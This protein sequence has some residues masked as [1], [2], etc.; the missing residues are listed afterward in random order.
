MQRKYAWCLAAAVLVGGC[1]SYYR[2]ADPASGKI[3]YTKS[4]KKE[5]GGAVMLKDAATGDKVT[6]QNSQISKVSK[7]EF[8]T[9]RA[10]NH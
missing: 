5:K 9:N 4:V 8:E 6:L 1:S 3:Y 10:G 7:E 2:V